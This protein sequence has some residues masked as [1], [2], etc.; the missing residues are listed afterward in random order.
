MRRQSVLRRQEQISRLQEEKSR[1]ATGYA[2][3]TK[4]AS[5]AREAMNRTT[6]QSVVQSKL[7]EIQRHEGNALKYQ[8]KIAEIESKI[9]REI[10]HLNDDQKRLADAERQ[11]RQR[12]AQ[13]S[14]RQ[15][16]AVAG[17]LWQ[18]EQLHHVALNAIKKLQ[19]LPVRITILFLASNPVDQEQL[20]L[21]EEVRAINEMIR[22]SEHRDSLRLESRWAVQP[23]DVLQA[24][25]ELKP[26]IIHFSGHG[27]QQDEIIFQDNAGNAKSVSKEAIVQTIA[28][29]SDDIQLVFFNTCYSHDQAAAVV[30]HV[31]ASIGMN[32]SIG[33]TAARIFAASFYS[34]IGFGKS[35]GQAFQQARAALMLEGIPEA[36]TPE[37][38]VTPGLD[39]A[40]LVLVRL[41]D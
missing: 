41:P 9:A 10:R 28:A 27:S 26:Q 32:T 4:K 6:S 11:D 30:E 31:S 25:N 7:R 39:A 36:D 29:G 15:M 33:D 24:V 23:L 5:S 8:Q 17:Q 37:L 20:H 1:V 16:T 40:D 3:E 34:A 2:S 19:N 12:R 38:Y 21:D 35:V 13:E 14:D 22:K 18:H